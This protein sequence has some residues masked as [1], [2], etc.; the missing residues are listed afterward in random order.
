MI[1]P[2]STMRPKLRVPR[3]KQWVPGIEI[4]KL[5]YNVSKIPKTT[6]TWQAE[7]TYSSNTVLS[8]QPQLPCRIAGTR[9]RGFTSSSESGFLYGSISMYWYG[10]PLTSSAIHTRCTKGLSRSQSLALWDYDG[11]LEQGQEPTRNS[12]HTTLDRFLFGAF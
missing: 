9:P 4:L 1:S 3:R 5:H 6:S 10:I 7:P 12:S 8:W 2:Q 11:I